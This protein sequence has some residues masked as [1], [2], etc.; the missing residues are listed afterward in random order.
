VNKRVYL[1]LRDLHLYGGLFVSPFVLV[2][3]ASVLFLVHL[4]LP[5]ESSGSAR[6]TRTVQGLQIDP[7]IVNLSGRERV[8]V[9]RAILNQAGV[10]GEIGFVR[11]VLKEQ[12]LIV[13]VSVPGRE[14]TVEIDLAGRSAA[15]SER[16]TGLADSAIMLHKLPGPHLADIRMNWSPMV[17]WRW[18]ADGTVYLLLFIS[19]SGIYLWLALRSERRIGLALLGLG[20]FSFFGIIYAIVH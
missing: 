16:K 3:A 17:L 15:I 20:A 10:H 8:D 19:A 11:H 13:P 1:I 2:F 12:M 9:V 6:P 5:G 18:F 4:W 7:A 14:A